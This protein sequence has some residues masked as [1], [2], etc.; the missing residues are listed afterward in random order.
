[1]MFPLPGVCF[2]SY[3][4]G[5]CCS[6]CGEVWE[7]TACQTCWQ[8][9]CAACQ[10]KHACGVEEESSEHSPEDTSNSEDQVLPAQ[11]KAAWFARMEDQDLGF[12]PMEGM[13]WVRLN[14]LAFM[15]RCYIVEDDIDRQFGNAEDWRSLSLNMSSDLMDGLIIF[16]T[17]RAQT[18]Q[19]LA[20]GQEMMQAKAA[21]RLV[22]KETAIGFAHHGEED[23]AH[24]V[25]WSP[26]MNYG[27]QRTLLD[28]ILRVIIK[29]HAHVAFWRSK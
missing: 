15:S 5:I 16:D 10:K 25:V 11:L 6:A 13:L 3:A 8:W 28:K 21:L 22:Q 23:I 7:V 24:L 29:K 9:L 12:V 27:F 2:I 18:V 20:G 1:M 26:T 4:D 14:H 19:Y 17:K